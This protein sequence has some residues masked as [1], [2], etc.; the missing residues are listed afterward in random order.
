MGISQPAQNY[1][2][3][4]NATIA[5]VPGKKI[6]AQF[7]GFVSDGGAGITNSISITGTQNGSTVTVVT[8]SVTNIV[9]IIPITIPGPVEFDTDTPVTVTNSGCFIAIQYYLKNG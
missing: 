1:N 5:A 8:A 3:T 7:S 4:A 9:V 2:L 6:V